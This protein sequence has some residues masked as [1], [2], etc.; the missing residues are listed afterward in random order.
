MDRR[1]F[2]RGLGLLVGGVVA[3]EAIPLGRVWSFPREIKIYPPGTWG[4][5]KRSD[6]YPLKYVSVL[7][8]SAP[9]EYSQLQDLWRRADLASIPYHQISADSD[10]YLGLD[11]REVL[12][13]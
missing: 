10:T 9:I 5:L 8:L 13:G 7:G 12:G 11:R 3:A 4:A 1:S 6:Y 2:L